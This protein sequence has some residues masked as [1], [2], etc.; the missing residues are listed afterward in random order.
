MIF[1]C[2][3]ESS[4]LKIVYSTASLNTRFSVFYIDV[5]SLLIEEITIRDWFHK[6]H[7]LVQAR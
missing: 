4:K 2:S 1:F 7:A 6:Y 5:V 3:V